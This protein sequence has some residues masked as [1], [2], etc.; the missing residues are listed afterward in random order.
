MEKKRLLADVLGAVRVA[1]EDAD[2]C[3][4]IMLADGTPLARRNWV[5]AY[6]AW[7]EVVSYF[8]RQYTL[9]QR[10]GKRVIPLERV[11]E[12]SALSEI[13]YT[14]S[15][16]NEAKSEPAHGRTLEYLPFSLTALAKTLG[17]RLI[18]DRG[19]RSWDMVTTALRV[20]NRITHPKS[21]HDLNVSDEDLQAIEVFSG[22]VGAHLKVIV[23][24]EIRTK[25]K[26]ETAVARR[27]KKKRVL[28]VD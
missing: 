10:F 5:R 4:A 28:A 15:K 19:G 17:I 25:V 1:A 7:V 3:R 13:R 18:V 20:R 23:N 16:T 24:D 27:T 11:P 21:A 26:K 14:L 22:W 6:F 8:A 12:F 9:D 2:K